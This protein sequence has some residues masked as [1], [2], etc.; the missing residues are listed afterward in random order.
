MKAYSKRI[1]PFCHKE[2][3]P[4]HPK[5]LACKDD[6]YFPC[7]DCGKLVIVVDRYYAEF[8]K[9]GPKRC[10]ECAIRYSSNKRKAKSAEEKQQILDKRKQTNLKKFGVEYAS[11]SREVQ[12]KVVETNLQKYGVERPLQNT[13]INEKRK[14]TNLR[15]YG[16]EEAQSSDIIKEKV[17]NTLHKRYGDN[18]D[19]V[20]QLDSTK[21]TVRQSVNDKY[22]VDNVFQ[23]EDVKQ[24]IRQ[25]N[26][27]RYGV[28]YPQ[29]SKEIQEI[30]KRNNIERY[31]VDH[32][33]KLDSVKEKFKETCIER[34]GTE[35]PL[36]NEHVKEK[37][38]QTNIQ[39]LGVPY[40]MMSELVK[41][42]SIETSRKR[43]GVPYHVQDLN[44][45]ERMIVDSSKSKNYYQFRENPEQ[46]IK[47]HFD[48]SPKVYQ[49]EDLLGCTDT[50]IYEILIKHNCQN[51]IDRSISS[52]E[53]DIL[54]FI[55]ENYDGEVIHNDNKAISP[56]E[57]DIYIPNKNFAIEC[58]PTATHNSSFKDP[59]GGLPKAY[60]YHKM[61]T[62]LCE[63]KGIV[64]FHVF[65][66][67]WK[68]RKEILKSMIMNALGCTPIRIY[69]RDTYVSEI[70]HQ[71]SK[72]FLEE[73]HRQGHITASVRLGLRLK[74]TD[75]LVSLMTFNPTRKTIGNKEGFNGVE[76]SRFCGKRNHSVIGGASKLF[77]HFLEVH[78]NPD[79]VSFSDKAHTSG[80]LYEKLG[81]KKVSESEPGYVWVNLKDDSYYTR[82]ACQKRNLRRLFNDPN[83]DITNQTER[84]IMESHGYAQVFDS[85]VIRWEYVYN[86]HNLV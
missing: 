21:Q 63:Q 20:S 75:E 17:K 81:F 32:T 22:G 46:F 16:T 33:S 35:N 19:N 23:S 58:D 9:H 52:M 1:C 34:Y 82:V 12:M 67:E 7:P 55:E 45:V 77:K 36:Q 69:A 31:G 70:S 41:Q 44:T 5:Q 51:L 48:S 28:M 66:Y 49:L 43:Y 14:Q 8:L 30:T 37:I 40:P 68:F 10:K 65:G 62:D 13:D 72:Q 3:I 61:K 42:K 54:K 64:L 59:W 76:L 85:G 25:T 60:N 84:Q 53:K 2:F 24:K 26:Q 47:Q 50:P 11:Q 18:I 83:I 73:N 79:I 86:N 71:E 57:L 4:T 74:K 56:Y 6:H 78:G 39:N 29:Q 38:K 27:E 80:H 15:R